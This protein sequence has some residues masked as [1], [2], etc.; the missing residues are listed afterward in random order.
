M[1]RASYE[2]VSRENMELPRI[3]DTR[4]NATEYRYMY[5]SGTREG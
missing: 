3:N 4:C 5:A 2:V 1:A